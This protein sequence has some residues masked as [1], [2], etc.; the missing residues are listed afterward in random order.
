MSTEHWHPVTRGSDREIV[1]YLVPLD[2]DYSQIQPRSVLGHPI[3]DPCDFVTGEDR[4]RE[5][6]IREVSEHWRLA[7]P[8]LPNSLAI[9]EVSPDGIVVADAMKT[10]ALAPTQ[11]FRVA[12]PDITQRLVLWDDPTSIF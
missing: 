12:W 11:R 10:K 1:G 7:Q 4:L 3:G 6:G 8:E 9:L 5:H 2:P